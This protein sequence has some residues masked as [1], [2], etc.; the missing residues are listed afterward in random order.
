MIGTILTTMA[1]TVAGTL[2]IQDMNK[3]AKAYDRLPDEIKRK[4]KDEEE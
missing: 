1:V 4:S 3:K 2:K